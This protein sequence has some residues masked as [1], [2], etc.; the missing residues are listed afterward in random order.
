MGA[1]TRL[2]ETSQ[3]AGSP[4]PV[5]LCRALSYQ[6]LEAGAGR[7]QLAPACV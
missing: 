2:D 5:T 4:H 6:D 1:V 7:A 3:N